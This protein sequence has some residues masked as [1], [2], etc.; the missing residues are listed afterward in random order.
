MPVIQKII[1][2]HPGPDPGSSIVYALQCCSFFASR[3]F[4]GQM[5]LVC[6]FTRRSIG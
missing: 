4:A 6:P 5:P 3:D 2:R 1:F